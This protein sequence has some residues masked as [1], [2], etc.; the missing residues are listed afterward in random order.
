MEGHRLGDKKSLEGSL[1][2]ITGIPAEALQGCPLESFHIDERMAWAKFRKTT[3]PEDKAYCLLGILGIHMPT[4]YG[5][6]TEKAMQRLYDEVQLIGTAPC[7]IPFSRNLQFVD[8]ESQ[9]AELEA[10]L[11]QGRQST[12]IDITGAGGTGKSQLALELAYV[13]M[14]K[15]KS[16]A[17]FWIDASDADSLVRIAQKLSISG[18]DNEDTN[19]IMLVKQHLSIGTGKKCMLVF[20][21]ADN[22]SLGQASLSS[23]PVLNLTDYLPQSE[24]GSTILTT[25]DNNT[26]K[27]L[28]KRYVMELPNMTPD[29]AQTMLEKHMNT[30]T[31]TSEG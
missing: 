26:A 29:T 15:N 20:D 30:S 9:L 25:T 18:W 6:G 3:E 12:V 13:T 14:E 5:E 10:W 17:V 21:N 8:R 27:I 22:V 28:A 7:S 1:C 24:L 31:P 2:K 11:S 4:S 16:C 19:V 23:T